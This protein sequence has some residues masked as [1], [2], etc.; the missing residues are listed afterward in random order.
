MRTRAWGG[1][2]VVAGTVVSAGL[3]G[4]TDRPSAGQGWSLG[5][6]G[7]DTPTEGGAPSVTPSYWITNPGPGSRTRWSGINLAGAE[8][9]EVPG[10]YGVDYIYPSADDV[11]YFAAAGMNVLR[12]PFSWERL[13]P[14]LDSPLDAD[15]LA[16]LAALVSDATDRD[17]SV[18]LDP[19]NYARYEGQIIG[20]GQVSVASFADFW[21]RLASEF[22]ANDLV[23]FGLMNEPHDMGAT[24]WFDIANQG[25]AAIRDAGATNLILVPGDDWTAAESWPS[26]NAAM[27]GIDDPQ[28]NYAFEV[29]LYL[30]SDNSGAYQNS[31]CVSETIG[32]DRLGAFT[33]FARA[34]A[35]RAFVGEFGVPVNA[36]CLVALDNLI[37]HVGDNADVYLGWTYWAAGPWWGD[38]PLSAQP[39]E[40]GEDRPQMQV[41]RRHLGDGTQ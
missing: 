12:V 23:V 30:D 10:Q 13:Q 27:T 11:A 15:E 22:A 35:H 4:C 31:E 9:G 25:I 3:A 34:G 32:A 26:V 5:T 18:I 40:D 7:T 2:V 8:F 16:R 36:N 38:Y 24:S 14:E 33:S 21:R 6:G 37:T 1:L 20:D 39:T 19:H 28:D 17:V 41:M 29:H